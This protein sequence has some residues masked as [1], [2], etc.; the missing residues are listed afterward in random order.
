MYVAEYKSRHQKKAKAFVIYQGEIA[1][2]QTN[3]EHEEGVVGQIY[4]VSTFR[5]S[6]CTY[7]LTKNINFKVSGEDSFK[8]EAQ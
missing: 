7:V 1:A 6:H 3:S 2:C 5:I 4:R 8:I